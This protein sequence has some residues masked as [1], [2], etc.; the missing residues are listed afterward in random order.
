[1]ISYRTWFNEINGTDHSREIVNGKMGTKKM[2]IMRTYG[3][4]QFHRVVPH[5]L[6]SWFISPTTN[7]GL[8]RLHRALMGTYGMR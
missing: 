3:I 5:S 1:M 7:S 8:G 2:G 6:L 4:N